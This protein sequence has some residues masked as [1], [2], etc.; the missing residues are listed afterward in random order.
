MIGS[1][2]QRRKPQVAIKHDGLGFARNSG[3]AEARCRVAR[4]HDTGAGKAW[5]FGVVDDERSNSR[6]IL[7]CSAHD[8][9]IGY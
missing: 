5:L 1:A 4:V 9:C 2:G 3:Q 8:L 6:R 7:Q